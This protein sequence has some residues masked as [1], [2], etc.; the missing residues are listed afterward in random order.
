MQSQSIK[1]FETAYNW[2]LRGWSVI[3]LRGETDKQ[4][5]KAPA[6]LHWKE[7]Q[8]RKPTFNE[9]EQWFVREHSGAIGIVLGRISGIVVIDIDKPEIETAFREALPELAKT[10]TVRSGNRKLPHYYYALEVG[11]DAPPRMAH[12]IEFRSDGQYV[13]A[14]MTTIGDATWKIEC[15]L[16]P[17]TLSQT[18]LSAL[19]DFLGLYTRTPSKT[20]VKTAQDAKLSHSQ[21]LPKIELE[22]ELTVGGL[23]RRYETD[24]RVFG[25]NNALFAMSCYAR[26]MGWSQGQ[27]TSA[28]LA[29]HVTQLANGAHPPE[30]T[31]MRMDEAHK[32]IGSAFKRPS[33]RKVQ[34][35][36]V[37]Q[38]PNAVREQ[39]LQMGFDNTARVLDAMILA[40][41]TGDMRFTAKQACEHLAAMGIGRNVVYVALATVLE[42]G[43]T[44]FPVDVLGG[45]ENPPTPPHPPP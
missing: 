44:V 30:T 39:L 31:K 5:P 29:T 21:I 14:P 43:Q 4:R 41:I 23:Q 40:G 10:F 25:R 3:P 13:V 2:V 20:P 7:Y 32:T 35:K 28:L 42:N 33:R 26:D 34:P 19:Y 45:G 36:S 8:Q 11:M 38:L 22:G 18:D 17:R 16:A 1:L 12:G 27:V 15:P 24:A 6:L 9:L 37:R